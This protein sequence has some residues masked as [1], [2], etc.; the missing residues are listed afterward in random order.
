SETDS[1][2]LHDFPGHGLGEKKPFTMDDL[3][4]SLKEEISNLGSGPVNIFGY[5]MGGFVAL[6]L[7]RNNPER[8]GKIFTF[9]TK[10]EWTPD[11]A[12]RETK[13]LDAEK[14]E[15][16]I[17]AFAKQLELR[18]APSDWKSVLQKTA[19]MMIGL[20]NSNPL[21]LADFA[22]IVHQ[23]RISIGD[24]DT[25]VSLDETVAVYRELK[26]ASLLV[27]PDTQHPIERVDADRLSSE[28]K[29][30]FKSV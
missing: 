20:G 26:N 22:S 29:E 4:S 18:H 10:F 7:C 25:M 12:W 19:D 13:M 3:V 17:P 27:M 1:V 24:K 15:E 5:S 6:Y 23:V 11:I 8:I 2:H 9:A 14:I 21:Q 30:F 16:K 28:I